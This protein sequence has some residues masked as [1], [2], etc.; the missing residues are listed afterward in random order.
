MSSWITNIVTWATTQLTNLGNILS[1]IG[2]QIS[3]ALQGIAGTI[4]S[5]V[6]SAVQTAYNALSSAIGAAVKTITDALSSLST[7]I[8]TSMASLAAAITTKINDMVKWVNSIPEAVSSYVGG[9]VLEIQKWT[10]QT[11]TSMVGAMFEWAKPI[12]KPIQD[13]VGW[14]GQIAGIFNNTY[15][16]D[17]EVITIQEKQKKAKELLQKLYERK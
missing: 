5:Y 13:A 8:Q 6:T 7:W 9:I 17:P 11:I 12:I 2:A 15:P 10:T 3:K 4:V 1:S 14:L 16:K